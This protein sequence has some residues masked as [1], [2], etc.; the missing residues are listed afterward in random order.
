MPTKKYDALEVPVLSRAMN[1]REEYK[2]FHGLKDG[3]RF[4]FS[5]RYTQDEV[6]DLAK[7]HGIIAKPVDK[8]SRHGKR[9]G[10]YVLR[11][12]KTGLK[13]DSKKYSLSDL[14]TMLAEGRKAIADA[15]HTLSSAGIDIDIG[16]SKHISVSCRGLP[17]D[18]K[19]QQKLKAA[20]KKSVSK[21]MD[22]R[23]L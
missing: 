23:S 16:D 4:G 5:A 19:L 6:K 8:R 15:E 2:F 22:K 10:D 3:D 20:I 1:L 21:V 7:S 9:Y 18:K 13:P 12:K 14:F 11:V 17:G